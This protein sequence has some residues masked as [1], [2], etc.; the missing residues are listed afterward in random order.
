M[1]FIGAVNPSV[2]STIILKTIDR[3]YIGREEYLFCLV[4]V[5]EGN[6][7]SDCRFWFAAYI[8]PCFRISLICMCIL[9]VQFDYALISI[10]YK[11]S[12]DF[13]ALEIENI[14]ELILIKLLNTF[15]WIQKLR[16]AYVFSNQ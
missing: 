2:Q 3:F 12:I 6:H 7:F 13:K 1:C 14:K 16:F 8:L 11:I 9:N 10:R 4:F 5:F 15:S